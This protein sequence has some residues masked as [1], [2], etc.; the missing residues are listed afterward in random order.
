MLDGYV[1]GLG[2]MSYCNQTLF[3]SGR[4]GSGHET[5]S[6]EVYVPVSVFHKWEVITCTM[7]AI[8]TAN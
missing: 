2:G 4:V 8:A 3:L 7:L 5:S 6:Y 1:T